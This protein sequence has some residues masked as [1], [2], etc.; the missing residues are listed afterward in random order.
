MDGIHFKRTF[1]SLLNGCFGDF[2]SSFSPTSH[3]ITGIF[4]SLAVGKTYD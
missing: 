1:G 2:H 4:F 3:Y